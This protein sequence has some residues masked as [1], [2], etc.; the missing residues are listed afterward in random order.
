MDKL[1]ELQA[2]LVLNSI[3][4]CFEKSNTGSHK[5]TSKKMVGGKWVYKYGESKDKSHSEEQNKEHEINSYIDMM[6]DVKQ[7][8]E[9]VVE[10]KEI[11][12]VV[13]SNSIWLQTE[14]EHKKPLLT[15]AKRKIVDY[16]AKKHQK[17]MNEKGVFMT[18]A[19]ARGFKVWWT[20][21]ATYM[22]TGIQMKFKPESEV[23]KG[24]TLGSATLFSK[25]INN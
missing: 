12:V 15:E 11:K 10:D 9:G 3:S 16:L 22:R 13:S 8:A 19:K 1:R 20:S 14:N 24:I 7:F 18:H 21:D 5:Y 23:G 2:K 17:P 6:R 4:K 25:R